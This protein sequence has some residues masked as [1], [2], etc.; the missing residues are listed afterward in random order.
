MTGL[1]TMEHG[2]NVAILSSKDLETNGVNDKKI[3]V[4]H[5]ALIQLINDYNEIMS[6]VKYLETV[7][8]PLM[9]CGFGLSLLK[10]NDFSL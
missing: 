3:Y 4:Q 10:V 6:G 2:A 7:I 8:S 1:D 9:P 5:R